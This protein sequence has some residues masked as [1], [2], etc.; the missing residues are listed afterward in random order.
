MPR[1]A[2]NERSITD[3]VLKVARACREADLDL[4][5]GGSVSPDAVEAL[6]EVRQVRL[7][8]FETRKV[9]FDGAALDDDAIFD[10]IAN[11]VE[12]ELLWLKNKRDYYQQIADEDLT[13]I[14]MMEA[15]MRK[16]SAPAD[17]A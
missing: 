17:A 14:E 2:I 15:R 4:V 7:D 1:G 9:I 6:R 3:A 8:R 12:F 11:A 10:G 5:V 16:A 13:R